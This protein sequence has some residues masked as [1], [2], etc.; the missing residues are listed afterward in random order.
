MSISRD[1]CNPKQIS[2]P[3]YVGLGILGL[4]LTLRIAQYSTNRSLWYDEAMLALNI[5][6]RSFIELMKPLSYNH[7]DPLALLFTEKLAV[8]ALGNHE[9]ILCLI[10]LVTGIVLDLVRSSARRDLA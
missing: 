9:F 3:S 4:G 5:T 8:Q 6:G 7:G 1:F 10:P 2:V